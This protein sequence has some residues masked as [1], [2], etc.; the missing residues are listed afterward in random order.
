LCIFRFIKKF[1]RYGLA[2]IR[3]GGKKVIALV[4]DTE[5]K[6]VLGLMHRKGLAKNECMLFVFPYMGHHGIWMYKMRF[7]IDILWLD[8]QMKI[9]D[10]VENAMPCKSI[11]NC[12]TYIPKKPSKYV[13]ELK[14]GFVANAKLSLNSKVYIKK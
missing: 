9:V 11:F 6:R 13:I 1:Q 3:I 5:L 10:Y 2:E 4:A 14:G 8:N 12:K 7:P